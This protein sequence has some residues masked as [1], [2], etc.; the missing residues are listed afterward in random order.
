VTSFCAVC[1][2]ELVPR[3][4]AEDAWLFCPRKHGI[5]LYE[6]SLREYLGDDAGMV[7]R[8]FERAGATDRLGSRPCPRCRLPMTVCAVAST[9]RALELDLCTGCRLVWF[10]P[11]EMRRLQVAAAESDEDTFVFARFAKRI[12]RL[13]SDS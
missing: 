10:D 6:S 2:D 8:L 9:E 13:F 11:V 5:A 3:N 7:G 1:S 12:M 4:R